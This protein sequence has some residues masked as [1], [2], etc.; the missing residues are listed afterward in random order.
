ST[1]QFGDDARIIVSSTPWGSDGLF[2]E[3]HAKATSGELD[4]ALAQHATS[5]EM[6]PT[7][8]PALLEREHARDPDGYRSEYLAEFVG[9]GG[10]YLD[11]ERIAAALADRAEL[12]PE[13]GSSWI[14]GLDPAFS[15][16]P[17]GLA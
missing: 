10:A 5:A 3:L 11:P 1:A 17:F 2:A 16:D 13:Q 7:L 9:G 4:D 14:A 12:I 8:D 15:S 6:N